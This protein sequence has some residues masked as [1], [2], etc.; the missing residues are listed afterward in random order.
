VLRSAIQNAQKKANLTTRN[1]IFPAK[2]DNE[3]EN[4]KNEDK[5]I[6]VTE[7]ILQ[8]ELINF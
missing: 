2:R 8:L 6:L 7:F 4:I 5:L 1:K 3:Q